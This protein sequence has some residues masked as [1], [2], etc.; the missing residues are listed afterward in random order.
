MTGIWRGY[1]QAA[2]N[3]QFTLDT[4]LDREALFARR[5]AWS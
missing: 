2:L 1:D 3:A 5:I 4:V